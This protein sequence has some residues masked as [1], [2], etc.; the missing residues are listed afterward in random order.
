MVCKHFNYF[1][2]MNANTNLVP[3]PLQDK[4]KFHNLVE[5][6]STVNDDCIRSA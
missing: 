3:L 4:S 5:N 2:S 6:L 1:V